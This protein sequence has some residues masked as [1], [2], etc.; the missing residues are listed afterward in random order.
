M[1]NFK[2]FG[3]TTRRGFV[4]GK[5]AGIVCLLAA[6]QA[7]EST[8]SSI[9]QPNQIISDTYGSLSLPS[10]TFRSVT[11]SNLATGNTDL[12]TAPAGKRAV[13]AAM[14]I[15]NGNGSTVFAEAKISGTYFRLQGTATTSTAAGINLT[16][17]MPFVLDPGDTISVNCSACAG[18]GNLFLKV[19]E[20]PSAYAFHSPRLTT[21]AASANTLY[22][23]PANSSAVLLA[24]NLPVSIGPLA[25]AC[26]ISNSSGGPINFSI[27]LVPS[28]G[29]VAA[30]NLITGTQSVANNSGTAFAC[31]STMTAGDFISVT[32][33]SAAAGQFA[34]VTVVET[35]AN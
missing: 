12:Y 31:S 30:G 8:A 26:G 28:G 25:G 16:P 17:L 22:T 6:F 2:G 24:L 11:G 14:T 19:I 10:A 15:G 32:S 21:L 4:A 18:T 7:A 29:S 20:F 23:V 13:V 27:N 1:P 35:S 9:T 3:F 5:C 33:A 34:W